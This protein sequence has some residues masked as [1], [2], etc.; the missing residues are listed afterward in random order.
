M[1]IKMWRK[2]AGFRHRTAHS[3]ILESVAPQLT[4][5]VSGLT[6]RPAAEHRGHRDLLPVDQLPRTGTPKALAA[7]A[8]RYPV[9]ALARTRR[10]L[11]TRDQIGPCPPTLRTGQQSYEDAPIGTFRILSRV[12]PVLVAE[13]C[14]TFAGGR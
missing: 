2:P 1:S 13:V 8:L 7:V 10:S 5:T 11:P 4:R 6:G 3:P 14:G 9:S 12:E